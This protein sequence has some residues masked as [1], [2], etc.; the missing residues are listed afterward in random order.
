[1]PLS[2][3]L[4]AGM[5]VA[6]LVGLVL[7]WA[8]L[9]LGATIFGL[10]CCGVLSLSLF[11]FGF[12]APEE[13]MNAVHWIV[14][15]LAALGSAPFAVKIVFFPR[16]VTVLDE[17]LNRIAVLGWWWTA[18]MGYAFAFSFVITLIMGF[19]NFDPDA[20]EQVRQAYFESVLIDSKYLLLTSLIASAILGVLSVVEERRKN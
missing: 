20:P 17:I 12:M 9:T 5:L 7:V 18:T 11:G 16:Q 6:K 15:G 13:G 3:V 4:R 1:M 10:L 14:I 2:S 19:D 8:L